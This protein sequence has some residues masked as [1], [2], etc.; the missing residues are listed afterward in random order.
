M[1]LHVTLSSISTVFQCE[2][3]YIILI[4]YLLLLMIYTA[5]FYLLAC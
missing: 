5:L 1:F 3:I 4:F 2:R